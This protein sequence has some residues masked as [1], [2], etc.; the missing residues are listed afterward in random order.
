MSPDAELIDRIVPLMKPDASIIVSIANHRVTW[1]ARGFSGFVRY[2][3]DRFIRPGAV[4][5]HVQYVP[6]NPMRWGAYRGLARVRRLASEWPV[7][8]LPVLA[9]SAG[10]LILLSGAWQLWVGSAASGR[11]VPAGSV[12]ASVM[13]LRVDRHGVTSTRLHPVLQLSRKDANFAVLDM[14]NQYPQKGEGRSPATATADDGTREPQYNRCVEIKEQFGLTPLGLMTNQVWHD[15]PRRLTF[16]LARYKF[17]S[18][19]L[20]GREQRRRARAAATPSGRA[21]SC[22]KSTSVTVYDF[23]PVFIED[24]SATPGSSAGRSTALVHDIVDGPAAQQA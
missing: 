10:F 22:R 20:S 1:A 17:V 18:K 15:D 11:P 6:A 24:I 16:L 8:G 14:T 12:Q 4:P 9:M 21:S 3:L 2:H 5:A 19:M 23:D 7:V 13:R